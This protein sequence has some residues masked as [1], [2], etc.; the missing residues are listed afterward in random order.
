MLL[1][2]C[3][4]AMVKNMTSVRCKAGALIPGDTKL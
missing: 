1:E 3:F 4:I 2:F